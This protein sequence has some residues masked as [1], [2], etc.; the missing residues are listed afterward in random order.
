MLRELT[1]SQED[2]TKR[3]A[4]EANSRVFIR[5]AVSGSVGREKDSEEHK[6]SARPSLGTRDRPKVIERTGI[7]ETCG[8]EFAR[9]EKKERKTVRE[10]EKKWKRGEMQE[11]VQEK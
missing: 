11:P 7:L 4:Q 3:S 10:D 1:E 2:E 6:I 8:Q 9:R 5:D